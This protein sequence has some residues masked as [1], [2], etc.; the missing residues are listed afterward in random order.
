MTL[1]SKKVLCCQMYFRNYKSSLCDLTGS[2]GKLLPQ[3]N[4]QLSNR[5]HVAGNKSLIREF[6]EDEL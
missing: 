6:S 4:Q 3:D 5:F 2:I 1:N